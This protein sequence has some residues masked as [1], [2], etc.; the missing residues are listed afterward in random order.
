MPFTKV[1]PDKNQI[2]IKID[3]LIPFDNR[4]LEWFSKGQ[5]FQDMLDEVRGIGIQQPIN[6]RHIPNGKYEILNG[7][8][9]VAAA[10]ELGFS[11]VP[12]LVLE[13]LTDEIALSYVSDTNPIG[14]LLK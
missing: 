8:Y 3:K 13:G 6:V 12:A 14:L 5:R 10:K 11:A 1:F 7:H 9:R 2:H 4:P